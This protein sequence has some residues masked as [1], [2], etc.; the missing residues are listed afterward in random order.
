MDEQEKGKPA[1][2]D[3]KRAVWHKSFEILLRNVAKHAEDG[4][5]K[6]CGDG[7]ERILFPIILILASDYEE[8]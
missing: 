1:Y 5:K 7:I 2:V 8:Q 3:F 4:Y 6:E